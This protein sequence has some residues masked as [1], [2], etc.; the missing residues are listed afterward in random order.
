[1]DP[2]HFILILF[3]GYLTNIIL[4]ET[5]EYPSTAPSQTTFKSSMPAISANFGI[6]TEKNPLSQPLQL[7]NT[8]LEQQ[9]SSTISGSSAQLSTS[10]APGSSG[11]LPT[12]AVLTTSRQTPLPSIFTSSGQTP[13]PPVPKS[14][15]K[16]IASPVLNST[17]QPPG[18]PVLSF[19]RQPPESPIPNSSSQSQESTVPNST[20]QS[21][22]SSAPNS[23]RQ[24]I[25][26]PVHNSSKKPPV[27]P[28]YNSSKKAPTSPGSSSTRESASIVVTPGFN[29][30]NPPIT[31]SQ[32]FP[33]NSIAAV[34]IGI[35]LTFMLVTIVIIIL[36]KCFKKPIP[37]DQNWAGRSPFA[38]G[39]TPD[40]YMDYSREGKSIKRSSIVSL[41]IW[42]PNKSMLLADDLDVKL[43][44]SSENF[45]ESPKSDLER[46][47]D[48]PN[49]TSEES[50]DR[51]TVGTAISSS[52]EMD[53]APA[54]P[55]LL[56]LDESVNQKPDSSNLVENDFS[57]LPPPLDCLDSENRQSSPPLSDSSIL[58]PP[59]EALLKNQ[60]EHNSEGHNS[61]S[62]TS[63]TQFPIPP[64]SSQ[65]TLDE[66]L[67]PPPA[68]LL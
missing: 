31:K 32:N 23:T 16:P 52:E 6:G 12:S 5:Q 30:E 11:Q 46:M 65:Q 68:E 24:P 9:P 67:P 26:T 66:M 3:W 17:R 54:P 53:L 8:S 34:L 48:Q 43:F 4:T 57:H 47:K 44:D 58:P 28:V 41:E 2:K 45:D 37:N 22:A 1:M 59:P 38:D 62:S 42:K 29:Q 21:P 49:G 20:R 61:L 60:E 15:S 10:P 51:S 14:S 33:A 19:S 27:T 25:A 7:I 39:E 18:S 50:G 13:A 55:P 64:D 40:M 35:I 36:W 56:D 63:E